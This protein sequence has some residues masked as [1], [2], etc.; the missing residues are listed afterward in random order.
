MGTMAK[1]MSKRLFKRVPIQRGLVGM[2]MA[3]AAMAMA[4]APTATV[5]AQSSP[6]Q[7]ATGTPVA[8]LRIALSELLG[9]HAVLAQLTMQAGYSGSPDYSQLAAQLTN[10]TTALSNAIAGIYGQAAGQQFNQ[11]WTGHINDFVNYVVATKEHNS[12]GQ[13]AALNAL[14]QYKTQFAAFMHSAD[15]HINATTL[16]DSLQVHITQLI[17]TFNAYVAGNY[18]AMANDFVTAYDHMFMDGDY[19]AGAIEAQFPS[20]FGTT[21]PN[22]PAVNLVVTLD[23]LLGA[24]AVLA[25]MAMQDGYAGAPDF[26]AVAGVL[27]QNTT[28]LSNAIASVYGAAAGQQF[29]QMWTGHINDFVN[30]VGATKAGNSAGQNAAVAALE[31]Y[32]TQFAAFLAG[33]DPYM[34]ATTLADSLQVHV[35]QL[36]ATFNAYVAQNY[37]STESDFVTAYEHMFMDGAYLGT[38]IVEQ[39]PAK[40]GVSMVSGAT[41][42]TTGLPLLPAVAL[43]AG[44]ALAGV[45][46]LMRRQRPDGGPLA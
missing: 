8:N 21:S 43:G 44:L 2:A 5:F 38:A 15:P 22:T 45:G 23:Q 46:F 36:L 25:Q 33:A 31:Q 42:P 41:S 35:N 18:T 17:A 26:Q 32:K 34:N 4:A 7:M 1:P 13:Q 19:L 20:K 40:F 39:Y 14:A 9:A 3:G 30:Y 11:M 24:H 29:N 27:T 12:A 10:N 16:A 6:A 28:N 37:S